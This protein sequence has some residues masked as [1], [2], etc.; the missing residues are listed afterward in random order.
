MAAERVDLHWSDDESE[1]APAALVA[2]F[3]ETSL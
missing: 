2:R 1:G 3:K